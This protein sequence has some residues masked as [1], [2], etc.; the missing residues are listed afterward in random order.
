LSLACS[1]FL[2][3]LKYIIS[4]FIWDLSNF[5]NVGT[6]SINFPLSTAFA[7]FQRFWKVVFSF[8]F[9]SKTFLIYVL[10][11]YFFNDPLIKSESPCLHVFE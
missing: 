4:L 11:P 7:V 5:S 8:S 10:P 6:H 2:N 9:D 1:Y 3:T